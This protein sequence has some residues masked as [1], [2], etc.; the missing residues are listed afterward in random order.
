GR[1]P[2]RRRRSRAC[3]R[4]SRVRGGEQPGQ[5]GAGDAPRDPA[6]DRGG[7][8]RRGLV[9]VSPAGR[10]LL[11]TGGSRGSGRATALLAAQAGADVGVLYH[12][13]G[14]EADTVAR[15]IRAMGRRAFLGGGDLA[16]ADR[17][18]QLMS[19]VRAAFG[20]LDGLVVNH[21]I[22]P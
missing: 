4:R 20:G 7:A 13:R 15:A 12:T 1:P 19:E 14:A 16:D 6:P 21:G 9:V 2:R 11:V 3:P 17:V 18:A 10:R 22:W 5:P 8:H